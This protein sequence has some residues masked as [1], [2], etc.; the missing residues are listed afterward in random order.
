MLEAE[1]KTYLSSF[2][3]R[4]DDGNERDEDDAA[5]IVVIGV[6]KPQ[7]HA[8]HLKDVERV[9]DLSTNST[10][11]CFRPAAAQNIAHIHN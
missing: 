4:H 1:K 5:G 10:P 8:E 7:G 3:K 2:V 9:E 6:R 11:T